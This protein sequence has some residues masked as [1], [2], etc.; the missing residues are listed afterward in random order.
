MS[1]KTLYELVRDKDDL[2]EKVFT[3][4]H[5]QDC[6]IFQSAH[7]NGVN[8]IDV[9]FKV[10][11]IIL[12]RVKNIN[13]AMIYDLQKYYPELMK[14]FINSK[15]E[16][17]YNNMKKNIEKGI[18][19][20]VYRQ[21]VKIDL[22][23]RFYWARFENFHSSDIFNDIKEKYTPEQIFYTF[24]EYHIRGIASDEG[25]KILNKIM[26]TKIKNRI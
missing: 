7:E 13:P 5:N 10:S 8:A 12:E 4:F 17:A 9:L 22:I 15:R 25:L 18:E 3:Y 26:E 1:K 23:S 11:E 24:V 21:N 14:S 19:E 16:T 20:G 6:C 2:I